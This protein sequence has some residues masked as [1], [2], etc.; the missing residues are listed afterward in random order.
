[1]VRTGDVATG[2]P[3]IWLR[4]EDKLGR[5]M[6]L[7]HRLTTYTRSNWYLVAIRAASKAAAVAGRLARGAE[8][9]SIRSAPLVRLGVKAG[10]G[11][12]GKANVGG[13]FDVGG[14][15]RGLVRGEAWPSAISSSLRER[16]SAMLGSV[17]IR[18][19][20]GPGTSGVGSTDR[21]IDFRRALLTCLRSAVED[22]LS[23]LGGT[24]L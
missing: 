12:G 9:V 23:G 6:W 24:L 1:M 10:D 21:L 16:K 19:D 20:S 8:R 15:V 14:L 13:G 17:S 7:G 4:G 3:H 22:K 11:F 2:V 18:S 5:L